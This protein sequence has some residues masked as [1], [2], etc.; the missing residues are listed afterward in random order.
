MNYFEIGNTCKACCYYTAHPELLDS[1]T[2]KNAFERI[3][4]DFEGKIDAADK[5]KLDEQKAAL[6]KAL[7]N[8]VSKKTVDSMPQRAV[9]LKQL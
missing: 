4:K 9:W 3:V 2:K 7:Q 6:Q 5:S 8:A 1:E